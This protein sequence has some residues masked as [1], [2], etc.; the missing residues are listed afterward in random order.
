MITLIMLMTLP[1]K[2]RYTAVF[3]HSLVFAGTWVITYKWMCELD[4]TENMVGTRLAMLVNILDNTSIADSKKKIKMIDEIGI[5]DPEVTIIL[6]N[7][8]TTSEQKINQ[9]KKLVS[10]SFH[11]PQT[12]NNRATNHN[13]PS[14]SLVSAPIVSLAVP[15]IKTVSNNMTV[16]NPVPDV[17]TAPMPVSQVPMPVSQV[18]MPVSQV[19]IPVSQVPMPVSQVPM[20]VSQV[21]MHVTSVNDVT[22]E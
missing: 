3:L 6:N 2:N 14:N 13:V 8:L 17:S 19:P 11:S 7:T 16:T 22:N 5:K 20:H 4:R 9:L 21:P 12:M 1:I 10:L 15:I 18:P